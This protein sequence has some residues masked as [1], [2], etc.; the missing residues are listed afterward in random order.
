[1]RLSLLAALVFRVVAVLWGLSAVGSL[2][3]P[4]LIEVLHL[5]ALAMPSAGAVPGLSSEGVVG[6]V[7]ALQAVFTLFSLMG[8]VLLYIWSPALGR[9]AARGLE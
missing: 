5:Y 4:A 2:M 6:G 7:G 3:L 1:M 8:A 9:L